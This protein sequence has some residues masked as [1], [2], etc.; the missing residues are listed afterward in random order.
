MYEISVV[1]SFSAAHNLREYQGKCENLHGHNWKVELIVA[2]ESL[3]KEG[4]IMDFKKVKSVL[5]QVLNILDHKYINEIPPFNK[6][7]PTSENIAKFV[8]EKAKEKLGSGNFKIKK[9]NIWETEH[10]RAS[11]YGEE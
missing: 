4:M 5:N 1:S 10:S 11:Y 3:N 8:Y 9:I 6:V 2:S 7:N